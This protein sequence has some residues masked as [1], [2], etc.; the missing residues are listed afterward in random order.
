MTCAT[1]R[2]ATP[3]AEPAMRG[4]LHCALERAAWHY[5][6]PGQ[7]CRYNPCRWVAK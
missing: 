1:C 3:A 6:R 2:H 5:L 4:Y 7:A